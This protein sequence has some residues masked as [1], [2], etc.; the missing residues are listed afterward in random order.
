[1]AIVS[2]DG[3]WLEVNPRLCTLTGYSACELQAMDFQSITHAEDLSYDLA[4]RAKLLAGEIADCA[5]E[6]RYIRKDGSITWAEITVTLIRD[7]AGAP[8]HFVATIHGIDQ[9]KALE[10]QAGGFRRKLEGFFRQAASGMAIVDVSGYVQECNER[11]CQIL[12]YSEAQ[13]R[14]YSFHSLSHPDDLEASRHMLRQLRDG[15]IDDYILEERF[16]RKDGTVAWCLLSAS[17]VEG[18]TTADTFICLVIKDITPRKQLEAELQGAKHELERKVEERTRELRLAT[19]QAEEALRVAEAAGKARTEFLSTMSHEIRTPLNAVIGFNGLLLDST[20]DDEQRQHAG[21]A[22]EAGE[23]LLALLNDFLDFAKIEAG[24]LE[25]EPVDFDPR[26]EITQVLDLVAEKAHRKGL[27]VRLHI[28]A[29]ARLN[30]DAGRFRQVLLNLLSNAIKFT[31]SGTVQLRCEPMIRMDDM[32]WL[33]VEVS[34]SGIGIDPAVHHRIFQPFTQGDGS[35]TRRHGGTGL[36]LAL[37]KR[38]AEAMGG[39]IGYRSAVGSGSAFWVSIPFSLREAGGRHMPPDSA[40]PAGAKIRGRILVVEDN[41]TSQKLTVVLLQRLGCHAD[42]AVNGREAVRAMSRQAYDLVFMD[43]D[44][45]VMDGFDATR[46][47][48]A[49]PGSA[50]RVGNPH[51]P[52]VALTAGAVA[53]DRER[54]FAA[55]MDD[56]LG[57]PVRPQDLEQKVRQWLRHTVDQG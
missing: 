51:V 6:K 52:I 36:G 47:I 25:L 32:V 24:H 41:P 40:A 14:E 30:G 31:D 28:E 22:R 8:L 44:M 17:R 37:C 9:R 33:H 45:P 11:F 21:L 48:R 53:G 19:Q 35:P 42:V 20:L 16:F 18:E 4:C 10:Q 23:H 13:L 26:Q 5:L 12:G 27:D 43:C 7:E 56:F 29:P 15:L 46:A 50:G 34:D 3:R 49:L 2:L 1:M 55:G 57:K 54:C 39:T 38:L